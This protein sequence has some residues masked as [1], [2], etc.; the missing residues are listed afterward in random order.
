MH[1]YI[2]ILGPL[3]TSASPLVWTR[4]HWDIGEDR[5]GAQELQILPCP[6]YQRFE[7]FPL[8]LAQFCVF[9]LTFA[10]IYERFG[11]FVGWDEGMR[12]ETIVPATFSLYS[13]LDLLAS[14]FRIPVVAWV[15]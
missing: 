13:I 4:L 7:L 15:Q 5:E 2:H 9:P 6:F 3:H 10:L 8:S 1:R 12:F 14:L 11:V